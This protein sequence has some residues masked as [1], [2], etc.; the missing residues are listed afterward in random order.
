MLAEHGE[1]TIDGLEKISGYDDDYY[2]K[3]KFADGKSYRYCCR[4]KVEIGDRAMVSGSRRGEV[5]VIVE[6]YEDDGLH[7]ILKAHMQEV[8]EAYRKPQNA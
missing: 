7:Y 5:G 8:K 4:Q 1:L 2:V 6:I 3:V